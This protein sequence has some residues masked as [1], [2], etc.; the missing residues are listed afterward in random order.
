VEKNPDYV[1][2]T[3]MIS[4]NEEARRTV[5]EQFETNPAWSSVKAIS[6]GK[7][8]YLPQQYYLY[9]PGPYY[10]DAIDYMAKGI[11]PEIYGALD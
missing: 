5:A 6:E 3:T 10:V 7:V 8:L 9:N 2:V 4:S 11:Y 1:L